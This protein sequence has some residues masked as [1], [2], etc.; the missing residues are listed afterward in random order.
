MI[1]FRFF[2]AFKYLIPNPNRYQFQLSKSLVASGKESNKNLC[3]LLALVTTSYHTRILFHPFQLLRFPAI[4]SLFIS[5]PVRRQNFIQLHYLFCM[6][7][8]FRFF[9]V[10][11][12]RRHWKS[13][14]LPAQQVYQTFFEIVKPAIYF[15]P[16]L[17]SVLDLTGM[18]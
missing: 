4:N 8:V 17:C 9:C 11:A 16:G 1:F 7:P 12:S 2:C 18:I 10:V 5:I 6:S 14:P 15:K 3:V 13:A